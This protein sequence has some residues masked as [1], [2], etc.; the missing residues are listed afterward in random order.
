VAAYKEDLDGTQC[1]VPNC[2]HDHEQGFFLH[3]KCHP[4]SPTWAMYLNGRL[5]ITCAECKEI[6]VVIEVASKEVSHAE[7]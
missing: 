1:S 7:N 2:T 6:I 3:A 4:G 5:F